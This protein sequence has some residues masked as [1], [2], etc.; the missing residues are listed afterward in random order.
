MSIWIAQH[1][2]V[3]KQYFAAGGIVMFPLL[4]VSLFL[5]S[6]IIDRLL[7]LWR[8][9]GKNMP[10]Q[11]AAQYIAKNKLPDLK[12][13]RGATALLVTEYLNKSSGALE[14][15]QCVLDEAVLRVTRIMDR[16]LALIAVL[17]SVAPLL[18]LLG[19]VIGMITTFEVISLF[20]TGNARA[21]AGGISEAL[22]TTQTGLLVAIPGMYLANFLNQRALRL[23]Q[24]I[25]SVGLYL[26]GA[27]FDNH[28]KTL[29]G[30]NVC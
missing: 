28:A 16:R 4:G 24:R 8:M 23:K 29:E 20:G 7:F 1:F 9:A 25:A 10:R 14:L 5:W 12:Q 26:R 27:I 3:V 15:D 6:L 18:G 11:T 17:A 2:S 13:H 22:I 30:N 19:T 21:M